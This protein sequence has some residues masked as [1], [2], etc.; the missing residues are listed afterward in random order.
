MYQLGRANIIY[1]YATASVSYLYATASASY[2]LYN[3]ALESICRIN[4]WFDRRYGKIDNMIELNH[5]E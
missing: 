2:R 5:C 4:D 3:I 1:I